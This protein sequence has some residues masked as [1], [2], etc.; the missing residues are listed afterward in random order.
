M[1]SSSTRPLPR[2]VGRPRNETGEAEP[3]PEPGRD[4]SKKIKRKGEFAKK[5]VRL[6]AA[7]LMLAGPITANALYNARVGDKHIGTREEIAN[8]VI[9]PW[10]TMVNGMFK[11]TPRGRD[12]YVEAMDAHADAPETVEPEVKTI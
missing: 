12:E 8:G 6:R 4:S 1:P 10:F 2:R 11:L 5:L 7:A 9:A 3:K